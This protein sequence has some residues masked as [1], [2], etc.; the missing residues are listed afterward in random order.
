M[1]LDVCS[2]ICFSC[3]A[4]FRS[5]LVCSINLLNSLGFVKSNYLLSFL[6]FWNQDWLANTRRPSWL[7]D[8]EPCLWSTRLFLQDNC[9]SLLFPFLP[10][11][12]KF[13]VVTSQKFWKILEE[14]TFVGED[15]P[16]FWLGD[17]RRALF[18]LH[19]ATRDFSTWWWFYIVKERGS[20]GQ[21][22]QSAVSLRGVMWNVEQG[23]WQSCFGVHC[24]WVVWGNA[25]SQH[26]SGAGGAG[27]SAKGT[28]G[29]ILH[30]PTAPTPWHFGLNNTS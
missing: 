15:N 11:I 24:W 19:T 5:I 21:E 13:T 16:E 9:K 12:K 8:S 10:Q 18:T 4:S 29:R 20:L 3:G 28:C 22:D 14:F 27:T 6:Q 25:E 23:M 1:T 26:G 2:W 30:V 7:C 17:V